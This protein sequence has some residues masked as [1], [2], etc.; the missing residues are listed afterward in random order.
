LLWKS[1][2]KLTFIHEAQLLNYLKAAGIKVGLL[3]NFSPEKL[4]NG[5]LIYIELLVKICVD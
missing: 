2:E 4:E 1:I 5:L 3:I